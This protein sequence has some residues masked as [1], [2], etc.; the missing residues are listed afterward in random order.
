M[1]GSLRNFWKASLGSLPLANLGQR[2][3]QSQLMASVHFWANL[4]GVWSFL[5]KSVPGPFLRKALFLALLGCFSV[6]QVPYVLLILL[7]LSAFSLLSFYRGISLF[8][9]RTRWGVF[10]F[11]L[12][13]MFSGLIHN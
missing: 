7:F 5:R 6:I 1:S 10:I 11:Q 4:Q 13:G 2:G 3:F 12:F 8:S 9:A